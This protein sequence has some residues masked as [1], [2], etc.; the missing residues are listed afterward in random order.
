MNLIAR[1]GQKLLAKQV[2]TN[3]QKKLH[4]KKMLVAEVR[5]NN[6]IARNISLCDPLMNS[7]IVQMGTF[8]PKGGALNGSIYI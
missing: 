4:R 7:S 8:F 3:K 5:I 6:Q 1:N 2:K